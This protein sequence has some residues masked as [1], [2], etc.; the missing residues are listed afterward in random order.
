M[1]WESLNT[2]GLLPACLDVHKGDALFPRIDIAKE[3]AEVKP[4]PKAE[5]IAEKTEQPSASS[6]KNEAQKAEEPAA[7]AG[8]ITI[9][10]FEKVQLRTARVIACE[11]VPKSDKLLKLSLSLGLEQRT[12]VSGIAK[13]YTPEEMVGR[14][15]VLVANLKPAKLRGIESGNDTVRFRCG[16]SNAEACDG[17]GR[18]GRRRGDPLMD[19]LLFDTHCHIDEER[20]DEDRDQVLARMLENGVSN[21][22]CFRRQYSV[23]CYDDSPYQGY[24]CIDRYFSRTALVG[25]LS[26]RM[27]R[28]KRNNN[29]CKC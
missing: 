1:T 4:A 8:E 15:V 11:R 7:K 24:R 29:R 16:R 9:D 25:A 19:M 20:F 27:P 18:Y 26:W 5:Q 28:R 12:V 6:I 3:L 22:V 14:Q 10:E 13:H 23:Y 17:G 2:F 21:C